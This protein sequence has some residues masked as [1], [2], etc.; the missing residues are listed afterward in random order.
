MTIYVKIKGAIYD[1]CTFQKYP[2]LRSP[3]RW[4]E[5]S[6]KKLLFDKRIEYLLIDSYCIFLVQVSQPF[7]LEVLLIVR[8]CVAFCFLQCLWLR[9]HYFFHIDELIAAAVI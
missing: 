4:S 7:F 1:N 3:L 8:Y 9:F 5:K 2:H 6:I